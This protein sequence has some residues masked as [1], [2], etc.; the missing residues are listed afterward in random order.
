M[1]KEVDYNP[2]TNQWEHTGRTL[3]FA[4]F[5]TDDYTLVSRAPSE[6]GNTL[7]IK[8]KGEKA[9]RYE[10]L[11]GINSTAEGARDEVIA[12]KLSAQKMLQNPKLSSPQRAKL[13][14]YYDNLNQQQIMF[15]SQI[16]VVNSTKKQE[17]QPYYIP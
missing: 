17:I 15:E 7:F 12:R 1:F 10:T 9:R 16:D 4:D 8:K 5:D 14:N 11:P 2:K 13:E 3:S 6:V